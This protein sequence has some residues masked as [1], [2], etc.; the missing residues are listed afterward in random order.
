MGGLWT[1]NGESGIDLGWERRNQFNSRPAKL[2]EPLKP[3]GGSDLCAP[4]AG[5]LVQVTPAS[6]ANKSTHRAPQSL[7]EDCFSFA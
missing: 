4:A 5:L 7:M 1:G 6:V 3:T 2:E